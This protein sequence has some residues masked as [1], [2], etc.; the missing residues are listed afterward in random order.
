MA[1]FNGSSGW[2]FKFGRRRRR[3]GG[4]PPQQAVTV[5]RTYNM[6]VNIEELVIELN[7]NGVIRKGD[8][9]VVDTTVMDSISFPTL[10]LQNCLCRVVV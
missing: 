10:T 6:T 8:L 7:N 4:H 3:G 5:K 2:L 9:Q 1:E